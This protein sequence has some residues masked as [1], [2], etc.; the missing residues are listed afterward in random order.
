MVE[1]VLLGAGDEG[2]FCPDFFW[3]SFDFVLL[4]CPH[5]KPPVAARVKPSFTEFLLRFSLDLEMFLFLSLLVLVL[6]AEEVAD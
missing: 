2:D 4:Y 3:L 6:E 5:G 1:E